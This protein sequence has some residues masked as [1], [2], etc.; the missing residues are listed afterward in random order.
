MSKLTVLHIN[1]IGLAIALIVGAALYF[2]VISSANEEQ[3]KAQGEYDVVKAEADKLPAAKRNLET[4]TRDRQ[5]AIT[6]YSAYEGQYMPVI[7]YEKDVLTNM[8]RNFWPNGGKSWPE[9]Y[10][11]KFRAY[12]ATE[13][14]T[15]RI[16]WENPGVLVLPSFGPDPNRIDAAG[17]GEGLGP[18]LHYSYQMS[19]RARNLPSLMRH[20]KN[21]SSVRGFGVPT[22][23]GLTIQGNSPNLTATYNLALTIILRDIDNKAIPP[24]N[25]RISGSGGGGAAGAMGGRGGMGMMGGGMSMMGMPPGMGAAGMGSGG[26]PGAPMMPGAPM[27]PSGGPSMAGVNAQ[28]AGR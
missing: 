15:N 1:I 7:G 6:Q 10:I 2:T 4:A 13:A 8:M 24:A 19:V 28:A 22:V 14:R 11:K 23:D 18:V 17:A 26:G 9:R 25:A 21:W 20:I 5:V 16:V 12:M 3:K 27:G